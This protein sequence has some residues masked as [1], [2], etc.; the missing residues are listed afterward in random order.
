MSAAKAISTNAAVT[1][2]SAELDGILIKRKIRNS[3]EDFTD[4]RSPRSSDAHLMLPI[5]SKGSLK[6]LLTGL[7]D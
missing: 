5:A 4:H 1:V 2:G 6:L 3:S 7:T